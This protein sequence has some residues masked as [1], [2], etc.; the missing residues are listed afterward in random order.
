MATSF[1]TTSKTSS[2]PKP[3]TQTV[4]TTDIG[5]IMAD[6][7]QFG[8]VMYNP[9]G[10]FQ[11][12]SHNIFLGMGTNNGIYY[13]SQCNTKGCPGYGW[14]TAHCKYSQYLH[15]YKQLQPLIK[16]LIDGGFSYQMI[17]DSQGINTYFS[18]SGDCIA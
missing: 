17:K 15:T 10:I 7:G 4:L 3:T 6:F 1:T 13:M 9:F 12:G 2:R 5:K 11:N 14:N 8:E 16:M 18:P